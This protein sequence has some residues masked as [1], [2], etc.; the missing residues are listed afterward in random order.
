MSGTKW[1]EIW[2]NRI[3]NKPSKKNL[4]ILAPSMKSMQPVVSIG[5]INWQI[6]LQLPES[7]LAPGVLAANTYPSGPIILPVELTLT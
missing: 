1:K 2:E 5:L 3:S 6:C 7:Y 4:A